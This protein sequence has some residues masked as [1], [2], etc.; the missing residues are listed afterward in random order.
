M[1][2]ALTRCPLERW[3][4]HVTSVWDY[5][6]AEIFRS[7]LLQFIYF[8]PSTSKYY[9]YIPPLLQ[10]SFHLSNHINYLTVEVST[11][12]NIHCWRKLWVKHYDITIQ[13]IHLLIDFLQISW[14]IK[15]KSFLKQC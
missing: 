15:R 8:T 5:S 1:K 10:N 13:R 12:L 11:L 7:G 9:L 14:Y 4:Q 2:V 3:T 6:A